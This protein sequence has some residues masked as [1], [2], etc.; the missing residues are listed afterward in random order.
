MTPKEQREN[1]FVI[2]A[3]FAA[4]FG[5]ALPLSICAFLADEIRFCKLLT[6]LADQGADRFEMETWKASRRKLFP[7]H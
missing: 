4:F 1:W 5:L 7:W 6:D 2:L 3:G